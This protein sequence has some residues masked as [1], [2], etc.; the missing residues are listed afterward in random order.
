[1]CVYLFVVL[2]IMTLK[3]DTVSTKWLLFL[4]TDAILLANSQHFSACKR[5]VHYINTGKTSCLL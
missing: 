4:N 5:C 1:M 3:D 2:F